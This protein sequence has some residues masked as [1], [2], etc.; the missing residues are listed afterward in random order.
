LKVA[1]IECL[2]FRG[3]QTKPE[4]CDGAVDTAVIRITADNG[5]YGL[6]ETDAPPHVIAALLAAPS[7]HV[8][9]LSIRDLLIGE[10]PLEVERLW[11]KVYDGTI[12]HGRRGLGIMLMSAIDNA[13]H[14]LRGKALG[15]PVYEVLG[16]A[17]R[18]EVHPYAT[19]FPGLSQG[20]SWK[21]VAKHCLSLLESAISRGFRA[22]KM[23]TLFDDLISDRQ[24]VDFICQCRP[25]RR[26]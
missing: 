20:R 5:Q 23:E 11:D 18:K 2:Q 24:W 21:E 14:D 7:A 19:L 17:A 26:R 1:Q 3:P 9:S 8:W 22:V 12:Y 10:N 13:L 15:L 6:G 25:D 4:D 16:G